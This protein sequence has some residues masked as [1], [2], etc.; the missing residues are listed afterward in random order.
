MA[1]QHASPHA[2]LAPALALALV[3]AFMAGSVAANPVE[4]VAL[5]PLLERLPEPKVSQYLRQRLE[6]PAHV[7]A[8]AQS[9]GATIEISSEEIVHVLVR[10][11]AM[12]DAQYERGLQNLMQH[13]LIGQPRLIESLGAVAGQVTV[14][15]LE[16][17]VND[18]AVGFVDASPQAF[19]NRTGSVAPLTFVPN[20][21]GELREIMRRRRGISATGAG[22]RIGVVSDGLAG[23]IWFGR[24]RLYDTEGDPFAYPG[25]VV[26]PVGYKAVYDGDL[27]GRLLPSFFPGDFREGVIAD[28]TNYVEEVT[29]G[30]APFYRV[31]TLGVAF[32][33]YNTVSASLG[34]THPSI[35]PSNI[36]TIVAR[37]VFN[38]A[39]VPAS[40]G[41]AII[42]IVRDYV[43]DAEFLFVNAFT[44]ETAI[45]AFEDLANAGCDIIIS[46]QAFFQLGPYDGASHVLAQLV[47]FYSNN[48]DTV[49]IF[50]AGNY[51]QHHHRSFVKDSN[52]NRFH[53]FSG[54]DETLRVQIGPGE[55]MTVALSWDE[56]F[57]GNPSFSRARHNLDLYILSPSDLNINRPLASSTNPQS[58]LSGHFPLETAA[59]VNNNR[60]GNFSVVDVEIVVTV[61]AGTPTSIP[62]RMFFLAQNDQNAVRVR[63]YITPEASIPQG[64]DSTEALTIAAI[65]QRSP[66][67]RRSFSSIGPVN[68]AVQK[69]DFSAFTDI[70]NSTG[71][72]ILHPSAGDFEN[73]PG[74]VGGQSIAVAAQNLPSNSPLTGTSGSMAEAAGMIAMV[75]SFA[76]AALLERPAEARNRADW[77]RILLREG[78]RDLENAGWDATTGWGRIDPY[79]TI[80]PYIRR[81]G[82]RFF[83]TDFNT[84]AEKQRFM[85]QAHPEMGF[86][87]P[88]FG[89][90]S[91]PTPSAL[92]IGSAN[93][94]S[95]WGYFWS[96]LIDF[97]RVVDGTAVSDG[98]TLDPS[99]L[100]RVRVRVAE[101]LSA[102]PN[103]VIR[104]RAQARNSNVV[105]IHTLNDNG[106]P[107]FSDQ[108][109]P[110]E[111][112]GGVFTH[113]F[114]P[115][116][117]AATSGMEINI[118]LI[119]TNPFLA[120]NGTLLIQELEIVELNEL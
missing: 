19:G 113:Y 28:Y 30:T 7:Q 84:V 35:R 37:T 67:A 3:L 103:P 77:L 48:Q 97:Q 73:R 61:P 4:R 44:I 49:F 39:G 5:D 17:L 46:D 76:D 22:L 60:E 111:L 70:E 32:R 58:G 12:N 87:A 55:T 36:N 57:A 59:V 109:E 108:F 101:E 10:P 41:T 63:E 47:N 74:S 27:P 38:P 96:G 98:I 45:R 89:N 91:S 100:Y 118:D 88:I 86:T 6:P 18:P 15:T 95:T 31:G 53:E 79:R 83:Y 56:T 42:D 9:R 16:A 81:E 69:P 115:S 93:N 117:S 105:F 50:A 78:V 26:I 40:K 1:S 24:D 29:L 112:G 72:F 107:D 68:V 75:V 51:A 8:A 54:T 43:P 20:R 66:F 90:T 23:A 25:G 120:P 62:L 13:S 65:D 33:T 71:S 104:I 85:P 92:V 64:P 106:F 116:E 114:R 2:R 11:A 94:T 119:N 80:V 99:K 14:G 102:Q 21:I 110:D 82:E 34:G 52:N